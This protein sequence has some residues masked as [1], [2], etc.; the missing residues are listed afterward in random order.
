VPAIVS[1]GGEVLKFM[2]DGLL[3]IFGIPADGDQAGETCARALTAA[4]EAGERIADLG[5]AAGDPGAEPVKFG[6]ALHLGEVLYGNIGGASRLDFTC[7]GPAVN[8]AARLEKLASRLGRSIVASEDFAGHC[9]EDLVAIGD[10]TLPGFAEPRSVYGL[11]A[12]GSL[13][14]AEI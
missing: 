2:G 9:T 10:F 5:S 4:R 12:E 3:A 11:A 1:Q 6:L 14:R 13:S 8:L 7:I